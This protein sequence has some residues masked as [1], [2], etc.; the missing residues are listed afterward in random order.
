M[1]DVSRR[2]FIAGSAAAATTLT[3]GAPFV[4]A[5]K[6]GG[7]LR[8]VPHA[9]LRVLDVTRY[10]GYIT[11]RTNAYLVYDTLFSRDEKGEI[12]PQMVDKYSAS[13]D[14][15]KWSFTLRDGLKFHDGQPVTAEDCVVSLKRWSQRDPL[16]QFFMAATERLQ[17]TDKK[18]FVL[19]LGKPFGL[20][21]EALSKPSAVVPFILPARIAATPEEEMIKEAIGSGPYKFVKEEW[22]PGNQVVYVRNPDYTPRNENPSGAAGGKRVYLDRIIWRILPDPATIAAALEAGEVDVWEQPPL[23]YVPK[24]EKNASIAIVTYDPIG[25]QGWLRPNHLQPPFNNKKAR[26]ALVHM[27][28][29]ERYLQAA[30]GQPKYFRQSGAFF[31]SK[32]EFATNAGAPVK[33]DFERAR[34]LMKEAGYDG[35]PIV[36]LDPTNIPMAHAVALVTGEL[37]P[38][39]GCQVDVQAMDWGTLV[40]RRAIKTPASEGGWNILH[41]WWSA[42]DMASP[43]LNSGVAGVGEKAF[44]GWYG[45]EAMEKMRRDFVAQTDTAKRKQMA[46]DIQKLAYD[47]VPYVPWGEFVTPA[48]FR[49]TVRGALTFPAPLLWNLSI[50]S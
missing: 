45:S 15:R 30:I 32:S 35:K 1:Q 44:F 21:L 6:R 42:A 38:K 46:E 10:T 20:V 47:D 14:A 9:D 7:T 19:E 11:N 13:K 39:I 43:A 23:D 3:V 4:H 27:V 36:V 24:L 29:Q 33:P 22:Q 18:T 49:K 26:Q 31:T 34:Q 25:N 41:T 17:A 37:L 5:Q 28:D 2:Q 50:E 12:R 16:G 40:A 8:F 48:A